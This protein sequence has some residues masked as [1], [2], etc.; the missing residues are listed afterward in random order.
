MVNF[1]LQLTKMDGTEHI[2]GIGAESATLPK[3][4]SF[5]N[6]L[7]NVLDQ[8][9]DPICVPCSVSAFL[10]WRENL[11]DGSKKDNEVDYYEIYDSKQIE[12]EGMTFK[13]AFKYIR[14][15]GVKS[16]VGK[17][18]INEY[19]LIKSNFALKLA[20]VTNGPCVGALPVYN[21]GYDFWK[22]NSGDSILGYHAISIVGYDENGFEIRNSWGKNW[23]E[24]GYTYIKNE[25]LNKFLEM[26]TVVS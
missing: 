12:G 24:K 17:L 16:D 14:H 2:F 19:A 10:N 1:G 18:K 4:Y 13:E 20:L 21:Y 15:E 7:P 25:D 11:K 26:W 3:E 9:N 23:G 8:G 22:R 6:Y 5:Q